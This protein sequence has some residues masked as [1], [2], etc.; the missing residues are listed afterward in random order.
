M[1]QFVE[2]DTALPREKWSICREVVAISLAELPV[3]A[4][5]IVLG[6]PIV[7]LEGWDVIQG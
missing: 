2:D 1:E 5:L 6:A 4:I 7:Y 3:V